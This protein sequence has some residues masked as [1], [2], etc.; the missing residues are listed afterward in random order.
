MAARLRVAWSSLQGALSD[1][2]EPLQPGP[3]TL[4]TLMLAKRE[5]VLAAREVVDLAMDMVGG[6]SYFR[7]S[8]LER[9]FRDV[10]AGSFHPLTPETTLAYAGRL[11]LGDDTSVA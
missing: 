6:S 5:C 3:G 11:A 2:G 8:P 10:R 7:S 4:T 1:V 9:C